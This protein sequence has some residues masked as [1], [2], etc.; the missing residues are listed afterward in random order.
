MYLN[1]T[2]ALSYSF[3]TLKRGSYKLNVTLLSEIHFA[4]LCLVVRHSDKVNWPPRRLGRR[5]WGGWVAGGKCSRESA[6][7]RASAKWRS[8]CSWRHLSPQHSIPHSS[9]RIP[10]IMS[11]L[12][13]TFVTQKTCVLRTLWNG[14]TV[15]VCL[16]SRW[17]WT[18]VHHLGA[19]NSRHVCPSVETDQ[20]R[21]PL[22]ITC[23]HG[24]TA[25]W[26]QTRKTEAS[27]HGSGL[28]KCVILALMWSSFRG[29]SPC[30]G[31]LQHLHWSLA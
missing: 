1:D 28:R 7:W 13:N 29:G 30:K 18:V 27:L 23:L 16:R 20:T 9:H 24:C 6:R 21:T 3:K 4:H 8:L 15:R 17:S 5:F 2:N 12:R 19:G 26:L 31:V 22:P 11:P 14:H 25:P 10:S